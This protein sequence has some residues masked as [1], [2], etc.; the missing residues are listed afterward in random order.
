MTLGAR[1]WAIKTKLQFTGWLQYLPNLW[2]ALLFLVLAGLTGA[3]AGG[4]SPWVWLP[5]A[6]GLGLFLNLAFDLLVLKAGVRPPE[7]IPAPLTA[8]DDFDLMR[9]RVSCRSFQAR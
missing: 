2:L 9:S 3:V 1:L 8:L 7:P 6:P 5:L 4:G